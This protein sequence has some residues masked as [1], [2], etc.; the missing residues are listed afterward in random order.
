MDRRKFL[1]TGSSALLLA[2]CATSNVTSEAVSDIEQGESAFIPKGFGFPR[3]CSP[4]E[5]NG[6]Y[7]GL[8]GAERFWWA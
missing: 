6:V 7:A 2:S 3:P 4:L 5:P 8:G 1:G